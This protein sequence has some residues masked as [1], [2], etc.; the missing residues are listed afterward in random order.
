MVKKLFNEGIGFLWWL[1]FFGIPEG[2]EITPTSCK[3]CLKGTKH[4]RKSIKILTIIA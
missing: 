1:Q 2:E 3:Y 4:P